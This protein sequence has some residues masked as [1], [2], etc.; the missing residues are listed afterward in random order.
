M[1]NENEKVQITRTIEREGTLYRVEA[2]LVRRKRLG[3]NL[4]EVS[5]GG[6]TITP[7]PGPGPLR[8]SLLEE[9]LFG[10]NG[11]QATNLW[12]SKS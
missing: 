11:R 4:W 10:V 8:Q 5:E 3:T 9:V 6:G 12:N 1:A 2:A 7:E